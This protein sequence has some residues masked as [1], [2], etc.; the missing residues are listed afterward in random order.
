MREILNRFRDLVRSPLRPL[1]LCGKKSDLRRR[2]RLLPYEPD[3]VRMLFWNT[4]RMMS[5]Y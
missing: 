4:S 1:R 2:R 3:H 5:L